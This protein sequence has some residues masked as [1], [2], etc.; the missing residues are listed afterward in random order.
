MLE[1]F[2]IWICHIFGLFCLP[3]VTSTLRN[4]SMERDGGGDNNNVYFNIIDKFYVISTARIKLYG[5][6]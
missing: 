6:K 2:E 1:I 3:K 5:F 4:Q